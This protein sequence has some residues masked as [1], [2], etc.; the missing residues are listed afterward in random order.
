M[1]I[2]RHISIYDDHFEKLKPYV[3]KHN[4]NLGAALKEIINRA[5]KHGSRANSSAIDISLFNWML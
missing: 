2:S 3:E 1:N 5:E 4:G